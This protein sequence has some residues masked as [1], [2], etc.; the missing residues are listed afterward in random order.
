MSLSHPQF[1][2]PQIHTA[3]PPRNAVDPRRPYAFLIEPERNPRGEIVDV[4]TLFLTNRECPFRRAR[5]HACGFE[6]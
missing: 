5:Q 2:D 4:A 6:T 3:R 1:T